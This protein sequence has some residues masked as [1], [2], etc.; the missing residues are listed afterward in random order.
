MEGDNLESGIFKFQEISKQRYENGFDFWH[1]DC[2]TS[3]DES[4][5]LV[6]P[7]SGNEIR[8]GRSTNGYNFDFC[9]T[10]LLHAFGKQKVPYMYKPSGVLI[11]DTFNLFY[12]SM[13]KSKDKVHIFCTTTPFSNLLKKL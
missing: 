10:P 11:G 12:P 3:Q 2:F 4:F 13:L 7:Q 5:C 1:I 8:L 6:T 9:N